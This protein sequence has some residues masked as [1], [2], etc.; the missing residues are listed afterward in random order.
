MFGLTTVATAFLALGAATHPLEGTWK[1]EF[2]GGARVEN[3]E[4]TITKRT[5][6]LTITAAGDSL[7]A[8]LASD[9]MEG[10]PAR[11]PA[12]FS[13]KA[14]AGAVTFIQKSTVKVNINGSEEEMTS[15]ST[16]V[17]DVSG[18]GLAG[19]VDRKVQGMNMPEVGPQPVTGKR[20]P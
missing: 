5:G 20:V 18:T 11:P 19:T 1:I 9:P 6:T 2:P 8:V 7:V 3:G 14:Q 13:A 16:W 17:L 4:V 12:R 10:M 15:V